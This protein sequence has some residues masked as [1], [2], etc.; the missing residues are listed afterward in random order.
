LIH[1]RGYWLWPDAREHLFDAGLCGA[2]ALFFRGRSVMDLG[3]GPGFYVRQLRAAGIDARGIDGDPGLSEPYCRIADLTEPGAIGPGDVADWALCLEVGEHV[4]AE[5]EAV[6]LA[7][8][9]AANRRG[10]VLSWAPPGQ[11]GTGHVNERS[12]EYVAERMHAAGYWEDADATI[13]L[14][15]A[16]SLTWLRRNLSVWRR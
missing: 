16:A 8:L 9:H 15:A 12:R 2:L 10:V 5:F 7:N 1:P 6:F 13:D 4:S 11:G 14:R 3:C